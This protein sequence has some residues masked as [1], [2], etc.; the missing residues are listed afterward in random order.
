MFTCMVTVMVLQV[1]VDRVW[2]TFLPDTIVARFG[3]LLTVLIAVLSYLI[4]RRMLETS[5]LQSLVDELYVRRS[6]TPPAKLRIVSKARKLDDYMFASASVLSIRDEVR[7]A[8][9][10]ARSSPA[11]QSALIEMTTACNAYLE[12]S[13]ARPE[14]YLFLLDVLRCELSKGVHHIAALRRG[15]K[16]KEPGGR[17]LSSG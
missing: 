2:A 14:E 6:L 1:N 15:V 12:T 16:P 4:N 5:A 11:L 7:R 17:A 9:D 8:R 13:A 3:A 10:S